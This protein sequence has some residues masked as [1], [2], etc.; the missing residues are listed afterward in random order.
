VRLEGPYALGVANSFKQAWVGDVKKIFACSSYIQ[1]AS[2]QQSSVNPI[3]VL[4][5]IR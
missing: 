5:V 1:A 4:A 3:S 2:S